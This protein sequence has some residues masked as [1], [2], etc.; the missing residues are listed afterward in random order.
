VISSP[1]VHSN[2]VDQ[3]LLA[4]IDGAYDQSNAATDDGP[5]SD[6]AWQDHPFDD[7]DVFAAA[8]DD[9]LAEFAS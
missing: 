6:I 4:G 8:L 9:A 5:D 3:N 1:I 7:E 2:R